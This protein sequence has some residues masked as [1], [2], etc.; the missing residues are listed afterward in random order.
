MNDS[1]KDGSSSDSDLSSS[2][3]N[4]PKRQ[5]ACDHENGHGSQEEVEEEGGEVSEAQEE[6]EAHAEAELATS[7]SDD[8]GVGVL[9]SDAAGQE[10]MS[11]FDSAEGDR[12]Q[13][14]QEEKGAEP[15][16]EE[17]QGADPPSEVAQPKPAPVPAPRVSFRSTERHHPMTAK[18]REAS[19]EETAADSGDDSMFPNP[20]G[21]LYKVQSGLALC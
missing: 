4:T 11:T 2:G 15:P 18:Q 7:Q 17:E 10:A 8:S 5:S 16:S 6:E 13:D 1:S 21:L 3:G 14:P 20:P 12:P 9:K 19:P